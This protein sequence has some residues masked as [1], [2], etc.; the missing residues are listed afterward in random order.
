MLRGFFLLVVGVL[1][2]PNSRWSEEEIENPRYADTRSFFKVEKWTD[3]D[4][5]VERL[6]YACNRIAKARHIFDG[7]TELDPHGRYLIRQGIRIVDKWP[8]G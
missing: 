7:C 1:P 5:H 8:R 2:M 4:L 6:L 3:D